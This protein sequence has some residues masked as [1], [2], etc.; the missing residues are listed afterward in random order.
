MGIIEPPQQE[1][2]SHKISQALYFLIGALDC[3]F[4]IASKPTP[5]L[6]PFKYKLNGCKRRF[7]L[8]PD[9]RSKLSIE[10]LAMLY[11]RDIRFYCNKIFHRTVRIEYRRDV[12][13]L[14]DFRTILP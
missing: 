6:K 10:L 2:V 14:P 13:L 8:M 4:L 3:L 12:N 11:A 9:N 7:N 5:I 1:N